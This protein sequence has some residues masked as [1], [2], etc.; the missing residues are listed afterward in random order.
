M[1]VTLRSLLVGSIARFGDRPAVV[2]ADGRTLSYRDLE[3]FGNRLARA[4]VAAGISPGDPVAVMMSNSVEWVVADQGILRAGGAKVPINPMLS[5]SEM[6]YILADSGAT[7]ALVDEALAGVARQAGVARVIELGREWD[8]LLA[9]DAGR[10]SEVEVVVAPSDV[11]L[12]LYTGG[13]TGRQKGVVH[14]QGALALNLLAHDIEIGILDDE[15][16][17]L[18]APLAHSAGFLL[19]AGLLKGAFHVLAPR[20]EAAAVIDSVIEYAITL[21]FLVPTMIYRLLDSDHRVGEVA[22][23]RTILY[24]AAPISPERLGQGLARFGPVFMQLYGQSEAPNFLTRLTREDHDPAHSERL[25]S[26]GRPATLVS[27]AVLDDD[28]RPLPVG[29]IGEICAR[30]PYVMDSYRGMPEKTAETLRGGWLH[31]GDIGTIDADGFVYLLD[32][33]N[34]MIISGG[35]NIYTTEVEQAIASAGV[36][37]VAV[38]GIPHPDWGEAVVAYIV[39]DERVENVDVASAC[40]ASLARYKHPKAIVRV[41]SLPMTAVGKID[42]VAL[43]RAWTGWAEQVR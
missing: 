36:T 29:E 34:D 42:K 16:M 35:L 22:S 10:N 9:V 15:R 21:L 33:K 30:A 32:R 39:A 40:E 6:R 31:T 13:T 28:G 2:D 20:F 18:T 27:I 12:I 11:A 8:G 38:V 17:L 43:R 7:V 19:Q 23:L 41:D 14:C 4:L 37:Q 24:G 5:A 3:R 26:C 25:T 1:D